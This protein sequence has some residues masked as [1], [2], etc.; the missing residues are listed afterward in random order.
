MKH[1]YQCECGWRLSRTGRTRK[2]Y[3]KKKLQ[4]ALGKKYDV[5]IDNDGCER[6]AAEMKRSGNPLNQVVGL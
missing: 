3:A 2:E 1:G 6:L 5:N 4:H